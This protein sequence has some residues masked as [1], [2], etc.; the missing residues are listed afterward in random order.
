[1]RRWVFVDCSVVTGKC[2]CNDVSYRK[3][4]VM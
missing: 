3:I 4:K 1:M 2:G